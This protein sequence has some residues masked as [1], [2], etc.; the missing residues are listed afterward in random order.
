MRQ[1]FRLRSTLLAGLVRVGLLP[2]DGL[3]LY[4]STHVPWLSGFGS[5]AELC[6][7]LVRCSVPEV[8]AEIGSAHGRSTCYIAAGL[9]RNGK[10]QLYSIDPH[11]STGWNDGDRDLDTFEAVRKRLRALRLDP[12]VTHLRMESRAAC[13]TWSFGKVD[14]LLVDGSHTQADVQA[15]WT[16]FLPHL[17]PGALVLFH[18]TMW[19]YRRDSP[20]WREDQGVPRVV[21]AIQD[22][23]Y[24]AVTIMSGWGLT[25]VQNCRGGF[26]LLGGRDRSLTSPLHE[27][28]ES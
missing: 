16:G 12:W 26:P 24:P 18:D 19:E 2:A 28:G 6:Y 1:H 20:Y 8:V 3:L 10:G 25:I 23:G 4:D 21:Q 5:F 22:A 13:A 11:T 14:L 7:A 15:D 9:Q 17:S 27:P